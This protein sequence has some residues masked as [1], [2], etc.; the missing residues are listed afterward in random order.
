MDRA[1]ARAKD[2]VRILAGPNQGERAIVEKAHG[3]VASVR[4]ARSDKVIT[5]A[6]GQFINFSAAARKAWKTMPKRRVGRPPGRTINRR[7]VTLRIDDAI[8]ERFSALEKQGLIQD[9]SALIE[10]LLE[11]KL[12]RLEKNRG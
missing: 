9:R 6:L 5:I 11:A 1:N 12:C 7:S 3:Q 10:Q 2:K 8:W 4:L